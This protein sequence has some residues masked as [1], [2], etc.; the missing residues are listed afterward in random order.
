MLHSE[1]ELVAIFDNLEITYDYVHET[2]IV[3]R[4]LINESEVIAGGGGFSLPTN[5]DDF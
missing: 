3:T 5:V 1:G 4:N 2:S